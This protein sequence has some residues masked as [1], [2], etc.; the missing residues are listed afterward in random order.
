MVTVIGIDPGYA[1]CGFGVIEPRG[2]DWISVAHGVI[3]TSQEIQHADRLLEIASDLRSIIEKHNPSIL[4]IE[5]LF[6][7]KSTTTAL[8]VAEV[9][10]V[11]IVEARRAGLE[12]VEVKPNEVKMALTGYGKADKRQMQ[13]MVKTVFGFS[14]IPQPDD[15][16]DALAIAWCGACK[17]KFK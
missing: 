12:I 15:A 3:T 5:E 16:A 2:Q 10:G 11:V 8:K 13:E 6:F 7:A 14:T 9:R 4:V 1:R 17:A